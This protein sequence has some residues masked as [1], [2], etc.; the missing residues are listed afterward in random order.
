MIGDYIMT[1]RVGLHQALLEDSC[2]MALCKSTIEN[3]PSGSV[4]A[5]VFLAANPSVYTT[6]HELIAQRRI[7]KEVIQPHPLV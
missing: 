2:P 1:D 6:V 5:R 3:D 7:E 4:I